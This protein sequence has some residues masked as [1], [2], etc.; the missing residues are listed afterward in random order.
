MIL[1]PLLSPQRVMPLLKLKE[2]AS[3][4]VD[5]AGQKNNADQKSSCHRKQSSLENKLSQELLVLMAARNSTC[6]AKVASRGFSFINVLFPL[7]LRHRAWGF[8]AVKRL[9][10][11]EPAPAQTH[12][13]RAQLMQLAQVPGDLC[14]ECRAAPGAGRLGLVRDSLGPESRG[15]LRRL[16][17]LVQGLQRG[18][19]RAREGLFHLWWARR[20]HYKCLRVSPSPPPVLIR[21]VSSLPPY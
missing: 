1:A 21:H 3:A 5:T 18:A 14:L 4:N 9:S 6:S 12:S 2:Y 8:V 19:A 10:T 17:D 20:C 13:M 16:A 15:A 11:R 7:P